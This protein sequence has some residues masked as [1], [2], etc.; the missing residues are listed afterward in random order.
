MTAQEV[1]KKGGTTGNFKQDLSGRYNLDKIF[2]AAAWTATIVSVVVLAWLLLTILMDGL[3]TLNFNFL[4]SFPSRKAENAGIKAAFF[5]TLWVM[6]IVAVASFPIGVGAA[7][8]LEEF[9]T[10]NW[11]TRLVEINIGNLAGVPSIIYGLL[12]LAV[13]VR[14]FE[15]LTGGRSVLSGGLTLALLI[16]P[17]I[18][19]A[20][21]EAL[22]AVPNSMRLAGFAL[23]AN[24]WQVV[25]HHVLPSAMPGVLTGVIL[26]LS[27]AIGETAPLLAIG[28]VAF[29]R[30]TPDSLQSAFT[31]MPIQIYNWVGR[32]QE[33]FHQIAASGII[34]LMIMLLLMNTIAIYLRNRFQQTR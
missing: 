11:F 34:V 22:R 20:T 6:M 10:D 18:I 33:E 17:V 23:G 4:S 14:I 28:A 2:A 7:I 21:R 24:Q 13:F 32:P 1:Q 29:I 26:A 8:Y 16:L 27:R 9:A 31:A 5:G 15:P 25:W 19:V 30:S 12:G 3:G